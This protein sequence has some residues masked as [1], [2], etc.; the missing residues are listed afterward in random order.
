MVFVALLE[1]VGTGAEVMVPLIGNTPDR[2]N[3]LVFDV[4]FVL[5]PEMVGAGAEVMVPF[6]GRASDRLSPL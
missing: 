3:P 5:L 6:T 1:A 2:L 4:V